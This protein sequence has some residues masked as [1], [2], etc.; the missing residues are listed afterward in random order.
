[1]GAMQAVELAPDEGPS[2]SGGEEAATHRDWNARFAALAEAHSQLLFRI[3]YGLLRN[4]HDA[5]DAVQEALLRIYKTGGTAE[6]AD[7]KAYLA[8]TVWRTG[9]DIAA[10]RPRQTESLEQTGPLEED[11]GREFAGSAKSAEQQM[12][13]G[14]E[15]ALL[16][17]LIDGLPEN[18]RLPLVLSAIEEMTSREV[19]AAMGVP[20]GTVRTRIMRAR[21]ELRRRFENHHC[22]TFRRQR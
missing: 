21:A 12:A 1:M 22:S 14:G 2:G 19:A 9:L 8:R 10:R 15:R 11:A 5:E 20:E 16:R 13:E 6:I 3:A 4:P 17:I 7:E 18:L